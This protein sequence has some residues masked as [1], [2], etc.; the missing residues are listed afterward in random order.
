MLVIRNSLFSEKKEKT[1]LKDIPRGVHGF[2]FRS[3][4]SPSVGELTGR[5][6]GMEVAD[7]MDEEG[8]E[9]FEV[10]D[11]S[12]KEA[13]K[14][15]RVPG[16]VVGGGVGLIT[17][18]EAKKYLKKAANIV[19][20]EPEILEAIKEHV[21]IKK[22]KRLLEKLKKDPRKTAKKLRRASIPTAVALTGL[23]AYRGMIVGGKRAEKAAIVGNLD[24]LAEKR[25]KNE[26]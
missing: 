9:P 19:E 2:S 18:L 21:P 24:R 4:L 1:K 17:G 6:I 11:K 8:K 22:G 7:K 20:K 25:K 13:K 14:A 12:R 5:K 3:A 26:E 10:L 23:G 15:G 16:A